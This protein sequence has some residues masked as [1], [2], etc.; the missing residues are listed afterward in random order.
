M[1]SHGRP[2][3]LPPVGTNGRKE[4]ATTANVETIR[5]QTKARPDWARYLMA[6]AP[7]VRRWGERGQ[8]GAS[9]ERDIGRATGARC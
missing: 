5:I 9:P 6:S 7:A 1:R 8:L 3:R 2:R 4:N